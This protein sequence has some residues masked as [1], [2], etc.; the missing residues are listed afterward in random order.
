M[1][2]TSCLEKGLRAEQRLQ[3]STQMVKCRKFDCAFDHLTQLIR[4]IKQNK[5]LWSPAH[6]LH[7]PAICHASVCRCRYT[8]ASSLITPPVSLH[9]YCFVQFKS[10][11]GS[12]L[13]RYCAIWVKRALRYQVMISANRV[14]TTSSII[15]KRKQTSL[16]LICANSQKNSGDGWIA[17]QAK[18]QLCIFGFGVNCSFKAPQINTLTSICTRESM[19][20]NLCESILTFVVLHSI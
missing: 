7:I 9:C 18:G 16:L 15:S 14:T 1:V 20:N 19:K 11:R 6:G 2:Y 3:G 8:F 13:W 4:L 17:L 10:N 12:V 5:H